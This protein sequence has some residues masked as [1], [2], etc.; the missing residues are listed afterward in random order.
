[1]LFFGPTWVLSEILAPNKEPYTK[2]N[3]HDKNK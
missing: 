2:I 3:I 1:M